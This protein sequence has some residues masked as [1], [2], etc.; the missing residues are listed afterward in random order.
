MIISEHGQ[1]AFDLI[2]ITQG[3]EIIPAMQY[4]AGDIEIQDTVFAMGNNG[5]LR[6]KCEGYWFN[7][8]L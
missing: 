3:I 8:E 7:V 2:P 4:I 5:Y 1:I 6:A